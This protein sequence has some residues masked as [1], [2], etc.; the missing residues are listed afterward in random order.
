MKKL[1]AYHMEKYLN[2]D[3]WLGFLSALIGSVMSFLAPVTGFILMAFVL[4]LADLYSGVKAARKRGEQIN[5]RGFKRTV[6]KITLYVVS[7]L[8]GEL[9]RLTFFP[10]LNITYVIAF[11][12]CLT[13]LQSLVENVETVT[14]V[15]IWRRIK[16][17]IP[18][19]GD[20]E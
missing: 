4:V 17:I 14:G 10:A 5:S 7:I 6:E 2:S 13:E 15:N 3:Y 12:I 8:S 20:K 19:A 9:M 16:K 1:I 11:A 18:G